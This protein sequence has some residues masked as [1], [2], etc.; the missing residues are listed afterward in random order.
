[1]QTRS[2]DNRSV[3]PQRPGGDGPIPPA[4]SG[5]IRTDLG[6][7]NPAAPLFDSDAIEAI[8]A[9]YARANVNDGYPDR[10]DVAGWIQFAQTHDYADLKKAIYDHRVGKSVFSDPNFTLLL[11]DKIQEDSHFWELLSMMN[12]VNDRVAQTIIQSIA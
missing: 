7:V 1:M 3:T 6:I 9:D 12:Q 8:V 11:H 10:E 2:V 5:T 4:T